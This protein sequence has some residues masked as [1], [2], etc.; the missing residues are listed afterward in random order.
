MKVL[1]A[2]DESPVSARAARTA[3]RLFATTPGVEFLVINVSQLPTPW[4]GAAG[5]GAVAPLVVDAT[6]VH[7]ASD[8]EDERDL[9]ALAASA[10]VQPSEAIARAGDPVAEICAVADD[11][12]VDVIVVGSHDKTALRRLID[13]SVA[14]G[15]VRDTHRPVLVVSGEPPVVR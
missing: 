4:V 5:F 6:W 14:A 13:P 8:D 1:I 12:D 10:G 9:M 3:A 15:V 7:D 2:L 11:R